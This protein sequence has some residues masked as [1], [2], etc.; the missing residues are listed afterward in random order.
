MKKSTE[1]AKTSFLA[2]IINIGVDLL[3]INYIGLYAASI[4]TL[5]AYA[6]MAI[7][8]YI[9]VRKYVSV[10]LSCKNVCAAAFS[11]LVSVFAYYTKNMIV[12]S[13]SLIYIILYAV[14]F[15][16]AFLCSFMQELKLKLFKK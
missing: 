1:I 5:V 6:A 14:I 7:Y 11:V 4:S 2:A 15:N 8:R 16:R 3:L 9:D 10:R 13:I 12:C